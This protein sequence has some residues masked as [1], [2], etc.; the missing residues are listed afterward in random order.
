M[1]HTKKALRCVSSYLC[2]DLSILLTPRRSPEPLSMLYMHFAGFGNSLYANDLK[3]ATSSPNIALK[4]S[5]QLL[6]WRC[7]LEVSQVPQ[8]SCVRNWTPL[9]HPNLFWSHEFLFWGNGTSIYPA[10]LAKGFWRM[11]FPFL[12]NESTEHRH[13]WLMASRKS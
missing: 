8:T 10:Y 12:E 6:T 3:T 13:P 2:L 7:C 1:C 5:S 4:L 11:A 9:L